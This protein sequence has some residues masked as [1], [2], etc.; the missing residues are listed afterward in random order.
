MLT[1]VTI[2]VGLLLGV[3]TGPLLGWR[4]NPRHRRAGLCRW[5]LLV[6]GLVL[7][8]AADHVA[9]A[10]LAQLAVVAG[11]VSLVAFAVSNRRMVGMGLAALGLC[12]N[13]LV[14]TVDGGMPVRPGAVVGA[15]LAHGGV[16]GRPQGHRHHLENG[17]D[18]LTVL[19]DSIAFPVF[20]EVVS[21]GDLILLVGVAEV[22]AHLVPTTIPA[23]R[24]RTR[25]R[26]ARAVP[27]PAH[28]VT[29]AVV[30]AGRVGDDDRD[31]TAERFYPPPPPPP[32]L[33]AGDL[34]GV[35]LPRLQ[36]AGT[37]SGRGR[38]PASVDP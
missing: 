37:G 2:L 19:D 7:T 26:P 8:V 31:D 4:R 23:V 18:Q 32:R 15:G 3:V 9:N 33:S 38:V 13:A 27:P 20:H 24:L 5:W 21:I 1:V 30:G 16:V 12:L 29:P 35:A 36:E 6:V 10:A 34:E 25:R 11:Y 14:I 17:G 22:M 28:A